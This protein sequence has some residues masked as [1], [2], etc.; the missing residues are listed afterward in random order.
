MKLLPVLT[1][2][3]S[4]CLLGFSVSAEESPAQTDIPQSVSKSAPVLLIDNAHTYPDMPQSYAQGYEPLIDGNEAVIVLPLCCEDDEKPESVRISA[5]VTPDSPFIVRNYEQ[6]VPLALHADTDGAEHEIYLAKFRLAMHPERMNG[7][8]PVLLQT[9]DSGAYTVYVNITDGTDPHAETPAPEPEPVYEPE[10]VQTEPPVILMPK[11]L[12]Q[13]V[14]GSTVQAGDSA[15]LHITLKNTSHTEP[16]QNLTV[17]AA[18][19][20]P[21]HL[22]SADT[23]YFERIAA[24]AEFEAVFVCQVPPDAA[25]GSYTLPLQFDFAYGRGMNGAGS[26]NVSMEVTQPV[27]MDFPQVVLPAEAVVSDRLE[28]HIQAINLG[29]TAAQNVRAELSCEGL[30]P[31][32]TAFLGTVSGGTSAECVLPVQVT[33]KRGAALYGDTAGQITF[34]Y[35]DESGAE[36]T[37]TQQIALELKSPFSERRTEPEQASPKYWV[38]IMAGIGGGILLLAGY[39]MFR[40]RKRVQ[41]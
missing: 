18:A 7:C 4:A 20:A 10:P 17:T 3:I 32:G 35:T 39:L 31:E 23:L 8:Y 33:A 11:I 5:K 14:T 26:G 21:V 22:Q 30:L 2:L 12:V 38:W 40:R 29:V 28:L 25:A 27:K 15:A 13:G 41:P 6:T 24:D 1:V 36:H 16:L 9:A 37:E 19:A 34:T